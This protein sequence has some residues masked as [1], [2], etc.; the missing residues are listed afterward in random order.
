MSKKDQKRIGDTPIEARL[1]DLMNGLA[2]GIDEVLNGEPY[3]KNPKNGFI[4]M[5]FPING[6]DGR[7]NYISNVTRDG[8]LSMLKDQVERFEE[9]E[10]HATE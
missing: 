9:G 3:S 8:V 10:D 2:S 5:V 7:A 1:R 6:H 4:L